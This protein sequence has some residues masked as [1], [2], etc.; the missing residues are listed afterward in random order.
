MQ[1]LCLNSEQNTEQ[2]VKSWKENG[3]AKW[4]TVE[5]CKKNHLSAS[6]LPVATRFNSDL[7]LIHR[8]PHIRGLSEGRRV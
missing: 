1:E 3:V 6:L 2:I 8:E 4:R 7:P 5:V